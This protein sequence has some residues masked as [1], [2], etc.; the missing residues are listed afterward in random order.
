MSDDDLTM[1]QAAAIAGYTSPTYLHRAARSGRLRTTRQGRFGVRL[2]TRAWLEAFLAGRDLRAAAGRR[3]LPAAWGG[4]RGGLGTEGDGG[5]LTIPE[6]ARRA[7][8]AAA[9]TLYAAAKAGRLRTRT[10]G[11]FPYLTT[12]QWLDAFLADLRYNTEARGQAARGR[13]NDVVVSAQ[14]AGLSDRA[15]RAI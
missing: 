4:E 1:A 10:E 12:Q 14:R 13:G 6:A 11:V 15:P 7:G 9:S 8:Y 3:G 5:W 2:T